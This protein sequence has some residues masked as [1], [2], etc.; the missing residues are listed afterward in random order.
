LAEFGEFGELKEE[1][2]TTP[3]FGHPSFVR[4]GAIS[5]SDL[6]LRISD[7]KRITPSFGRPCG[8][9]SSQLLKNIK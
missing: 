4:K 7:W 6:G 2:R 5:I 3:A 9:I 8:H 1:E